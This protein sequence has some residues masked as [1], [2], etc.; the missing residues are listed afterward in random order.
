PISSCSIPQLT[1]ARSA[2]QYGACAPTQENSVRELI[3][4]STRNAVAGG[5]HL[6][7]KRTQCQSH[8]ATKKP[9]PR[10]GLSGLSQKSPGRGR[11]FQVFQVREKSV[12]GDDR[13]GPVEAI[14]QRGRNRLGPGV[15]PKAVTSESVGAVDQLIDGLA[16]IESRAVLGLHKPAWGGDA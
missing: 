14:D 3:P 5:A 2:A 7:P 1:S 8:P 16:V 4:G 11:G 6:S 13:T 10:P 12:L 9:R 15:E